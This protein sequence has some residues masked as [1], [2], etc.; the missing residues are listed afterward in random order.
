MSLLWIERC[1]KKLSTINYKKGNPSPTHQSNLPD[2]ARNPEIF[3]DGGKCRTSI[4]FLFIEG[5]LLFASRSKK[6]KAGMTVEASIVLPLF[7]FFFLNLGCAIE[8]IRLHGNLQLGLWQIGSRLSV[9]GYALDSGE[10]PG[11]S[12]GEDNW[13]ADLSGVAMAPVY[14]KS[15][16]IN[17]VGEAYLNRSPLTNGAA[18]LQFWESEIFGSE[19]EIDIIVTYSVSPWNSMAGFSSFRLANR[20]YSHIWNGYDLSGVEEGTQIVYITE[21]GTVYH[22][23]RNCTHLQ[24]S[25]R[26][27]LEADLDAM[28]NQYGGKYQRCE[29]CASGGTP[30]ILYITEE[31]NRYHYSRECSGLKRT[32]YSI[33]IEEAIEEGYRACARCGY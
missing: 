6:V 14:V 27:I 18:G 28:R 10:T 22:G 25:I 29:K 33:S 5:T 30:G 15:Q 16:I 17:S 26:Q 31:G 19:D 23:S 21:T 4:A 24:L 9:Y 8:M 11:E 3:S 13:W 20:Y 7:L 32:V 1:R 12:E 2:S